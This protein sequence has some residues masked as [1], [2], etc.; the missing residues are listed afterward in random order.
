MPKKAIKKP[1]VQGASALFFTSLHDLVRTHGDLSAASIGER[2]PRSRQ[3]VYRALAGPQLP[4]QRIT[5]EIARAV[6]CTEE[7]VENLLALWAD[8]VGEKR[9]STPPVRTWPDLSESERATDRSSSIRNF[10]RQLTILREESGLT[11]REVARRTDS[12]ASTIGG[13][14]AG[15]HLPPRQYLMALL[16]AMGRPSSDVEHWLQLLNEA[17]AGRN[18]PPADGTAK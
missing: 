2:I 9:T 18:S 7:Q 1:P 5:G 15:R 4:S 13:Y 11:V 16:Q 12:S 3:A 10:G 6:G 17:R 14:F 8:A